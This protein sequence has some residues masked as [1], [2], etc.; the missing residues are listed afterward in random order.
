MSP[1]RMS[2]PPEQGPLRSSGE[3]HCHAGAT[4]G[5]RNLRGGNRQA[6]AQGCPAPAQSL[7]IE[8]ERSGPGHY[9]G[10]LTVRFLPAK[11]ERLFE[12]YGVTVVVE[13]APPMLVLPVWKAPEGTDLWEDNLWRNAWLDLK[14][15]QSL[16]PIIVP[17]GDLE[18]TS[19]ITP[20]EALKLD[21]IKLEALR[22][23]YEPNHSGGHCRA[24]RRRHSRHD[25]WRFRLGKVTFDKIYTAERHAEASAAARRPALPCRHAGE[26]HVGQDRR[27]RQAEAERH[28]SPIRFPCRVPFASPSDGTPSA[29]ASCRRRASSALMYRPSPPMAPSSACCMLATCR[30]CRRQCRELACNCRKWAG[31]GSF[32]P[33]C[34]AH[35]PAKFHHH[36]PDPAG[37]GHHLADRLRRI[38][39]AF[40]VFIVAGVSDG[41]DGYIARRFDQRSSAPISTR[42]PTSCCWSRSIFRSGFL[43]FMPAWLV[44][45]VVSRDV[46]I[47]GAVILSWIL[48][49]PMMC[50]FIVSK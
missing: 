45:L 30:T 20:E 3:G 7:S 10:K 11:I 19:A 47:V 39:L 14:A 2:P 15:E 25:A 5:Q 38:W 13:Q 8:E 43:Q 34:N 27:A 1:T 23:R 44:I 35:E 36:R 6:G 9:I 49:K 16:V 50:P 41:V 48:G 12:S 31:H 46:L 40:L 28:A 24:R 37:A 22:R 32:S 18:D 4:A 26:I 17:I 42:L 21:P 29:R 33:F